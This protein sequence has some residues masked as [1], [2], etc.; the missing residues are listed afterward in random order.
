M[1]LTFLA[2]ALLFPLTAVA[3]MKASISVGINGP[4][5][6]VTGVTKGDFKN[7]EAQRFVN[8]AISTAWN[9]FQCLKDYECRK[10]SSK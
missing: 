1:R 3:E 7:G 8:T 6:T 2:I 5:I 4:S 10:A 9:S